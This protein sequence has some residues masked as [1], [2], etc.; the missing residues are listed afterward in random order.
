MVKTINIIVLKKS[1]VGGSFRPLLSLYLGGFLSPI[2]ATKNA[3]CGTKLGIPLKVL[4]VNPF[5]VS[6]PF[7][8][9]SE[10]N[11]PWFSENVRFGVNFDPKMATKWQKMKIF[12]KFKKEST[13]TPL[14][15]HKH[16][17]TCFQKRM[18]SVL[19][20]DISFMGCYRKLPRNT[21][22]THHTP[23]VCA[24]HLAM[25]HS[26]F[27]IFRPL[28]QTRHRDSTTYVHYPIG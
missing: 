14:S 5:W 22:I 15:D 12:L 19:Q 8:T 3:N 17:C 26:P 16:G 11:A 28:C 21:F 24:P 1:N 25:P 6:N 13:D 27:P 23:F 20:T 9:L 2:L 10:Q 4:P 18:P 7:W